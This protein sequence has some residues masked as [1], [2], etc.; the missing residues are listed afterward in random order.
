MIPYE[1][2]DCILVRPLARFEPIPRM[3]ATEQVKYIWLCVGR[4]NRPS[5]HVHGEKGRPAEHHG[6]RTSK[7]VWRSSFARTTLGLQ[8]RSLTRQKAHRDV[9]GRRLL[10]SRNTTASSCKGVA[11][12]SNYSCPTTII[13]MHSTLYGDHHRIVTTHAAD[14]D[15]P[16]QNRAHPRR[17]RALSASRDCTRRME[18][19]S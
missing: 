9:K 14:V 13:S 2:H 4:C 7:H 16:S 10:N 6:L 12:V 5:F 8:Q 1:N 19:R 15:V 11:V 18:L 17:F 3:Y